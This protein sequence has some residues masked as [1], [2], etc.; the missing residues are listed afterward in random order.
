M[1]SGRSTYSQPETTDI[2]PV[3]PE[4]APDGAGSEFDTDMAEAIVEARRT[5]FA[6]LADLNDLADWESV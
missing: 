1:Q 4:N 3:L 6:A 5:E 2:T